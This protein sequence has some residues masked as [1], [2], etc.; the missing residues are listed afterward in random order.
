MFKKVFLLVCFLFLFGDKSNATHIVG[1]EIYYDC[2]GG[3]NYEITLKIYRDCCP[4]CYV[5]DAPAYI[6]VYDAAGNVLQ[7]LTMFLVDSTDI[8]PTLNNPC[9]TPPTDVCV[10][11]G[12]YRQ[13]VNLPP[14]PGG[15]SLSYQRCCRNGDI[16]NIL[17]AS[18]VGSTYQAKI[19]DVSLVE[20][21]NS[22][23]YTNFPPLFLCAGLPIDFDHGATDPDGDSL[24]YE[25]CAPF[26]GASAMA[27]Q[28][29][30]P[31]S[32][33]YAFV[34]YN[35]PY[36][37]TYPMS[38]SPALTLDPNTGFM[39][40]TPDMIG[41]WVIGVCV[42]EYRD[43]VLLTTNKRDFQF[44]VVNCPD[45]PVASIPDQTTFCFGYDVSFSQTSLNAFSYHWDFGVPG[46]ETDTSNLLNPEYIYPDSGTYTVT[47]IINPGTMCADTNSNTFYIYPLLEPQFSPPP[48]ECLNSNSF[49]FTAAGDFMGNGTFVWDFGSSATPNNISAQ[50]PSGIEFSAPGTYPVTLTISENGC[51]ESY[52]QNVEVYA[53]PECNYGI[54]TSLACDLQPVSFLDS[55]I[56]SSALSYQWFF[57]DGNTS[58]DQN[59]W[60]EYP[61]T[62][63]YP[64]SLIITDAN[65]C[66]DTMQ[67]PTPLSVYPSPLA[68]FTLSPQDTSIFYPDVH[69]TDQSFSSV[70]CTVYWGDGTSD[71]NCDTVHSYTAPGTYTV[72]QVVQNAFGC[73]D[74]AYSQVLIRP[75]FLF[76]IPNAFTPNENGLNDVFRPSM[77]GVHDYR[78][79][80]FDRWGEKIFET[81]DQSEGWD[82]TLKGKMCT[83]DV[84]VYRITLRDDV[85]NQPH[86]YIGHVTLV[87]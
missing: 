1:G 12:V 62:G 78:F 69:I 18:N 4:S 64:T 26:E 2:L 42:S 75:E 17:D 68:G 25:L 77:I 33:P 30:P 84:Y 61:M 86:E 34:L 70:G 15:Y 36:S 71:T 38:T 53:H 44:N 55:S 11:E 40:G 24:Y 74:T 20:C 32:P 80:I 9:F 3:D 76:W 83:N 13:I 56:A 5:F 57:G 6:G 16:L 60:H 37:S 82:G 59:P 48:G 65:G 21:N 63:T 85:L 46:I 28:P 54:A 87:R 49:S 22:P 8:P 79:M 52:T 43:G 58:A 10:K 7:T 73:L 45:L 35:A 27:P 29:I 19:L 23:R 51:V 66:S 14:I 67:Y 72:M 39:T 41:R 31:S 50:N 47:L 81:K